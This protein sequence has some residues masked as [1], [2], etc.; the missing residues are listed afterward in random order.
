LERI[1]S[2]NGKRRKKKEKNYKKIFR[3]IEI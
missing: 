1:S 2:E 3:I